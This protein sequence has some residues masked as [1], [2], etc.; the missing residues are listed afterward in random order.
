MLAQH[1]YSKS[2]VLPDCFRKCEEIDL[3][4][5]FLQPSLI[6]NLA[7]GRAGGFVARHSISNVELFTHFEVEL[8]FLIQIVGKFLSVEESLYSL[9]PTHICLSS[10]TGC[11]I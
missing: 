4:H 9:S 7:P 3:A 11:E 6:A 8:Q 1:P 10:F 2:K 5:L